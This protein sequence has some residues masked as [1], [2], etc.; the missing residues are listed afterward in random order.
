MRYSSVQHSDNSCSPSISQMCTLLQYFCDC[1]LRHRVEGIV[2]YSDE[3]VQEIQRDQRVRYNLL[4]R[5]FTM[6]AAETARKTREF[7]SPPQ[8]QVLVQL[9]CRCQITDAFFVSKCASVTRCSVKH[10]TGNTRNQV[11]T[12][13]F[14]QQKYIDQNTLMGFSYFLPPQGSFADEF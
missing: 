2:A 9:V 14:V 12:F 5:A 10:D 8:D 1:E 13:G 6:S 11:N 7:R 4:M 3:F